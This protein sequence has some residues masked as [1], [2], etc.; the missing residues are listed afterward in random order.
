MIQYVRPNVTSYAHDKWFQF[1]FSR[2]GFRIILFVSP[3]SFAEKSA[4]DF[5]LRKGFRIIFICGS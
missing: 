1:L 4:V 3:T 5:V 2:K